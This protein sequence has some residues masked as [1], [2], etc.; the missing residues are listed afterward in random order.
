MLKSHIQLPEDVDMDQVQPSEVSQW[1]LAVAHQQ[2]PSVGQG[3]SSSLRRSQPVCGARELTKRFVTDRGGSRSS[4]EHRVSA[5]GSGCSNCQTRGCRK[6]SSFGTCSHPV[7]CAWVLARDE[8]RHTAGAGGCVSAG[9]R[10][11]SARATAGRISGRAREFARG[12][13]AH[14]CVF[15]GMCVC[16][17]TRVRR[18]RLGMLALG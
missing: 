2:D 5:V 4:G 9:V 10:V 1:G 7:G 3:M 17:C 18:A 13:C 16:A 15:V 11:Y 14:I 12:R 6:R 8:L